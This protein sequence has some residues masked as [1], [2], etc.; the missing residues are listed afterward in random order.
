MIYRSCTARW[1]ERMMDRIRYEK[2]EM[3]LQKPVCIFQ[4]EGNKAVPARY[5]RKDKQNTDKSES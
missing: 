3:Q 4:R 1:Q 2:L 5:I